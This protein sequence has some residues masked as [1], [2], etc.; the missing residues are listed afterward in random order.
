MRVLVTIPHYYQPVAEVTR[1]G[2]HSASARDARRL[3]LESCIFQLRSLFG[4]RHYAARHESHSI[5]PAPN[6]HALDVDVVVCTT[7]G[8]HLLDELACPPGLYHHLPTNAE[9]PYLGWECHSLLKEAI[10]SYD[11]YCYLEDDLII[12]DPFFFAKLELVNGHWR[13]IGDDGALLQPQR[14]EHSLRL[15]GGSG[16]PGTLERLYVDYSAGDRPVHDDAPI[17]IEHL[18]MTFRIA[19]TT[20]P[21]AGCF[22]LTDAQMRRL[23]AHPVFLKRDQIW[24][25]PLDTAATLGI[26]QAF[27]VFKPTLDSLSFLEICH[28]HPAVLREVAVGEAGVPVWQ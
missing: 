8:A 28:G 3:A 1:H 18:G 22:F 4:R 6:P 26:A 11:Y 17:E 19:P 13:S 5:A 25:S 15:E 10:G 14:Y 23:A 12:H 9:P 21:H 2:S 20:H 24:V 7:R 16:V 27:R